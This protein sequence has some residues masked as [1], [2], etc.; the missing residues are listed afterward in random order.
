MRKDKNHFIGRYNTVIG[1]SS[2]KRVEFKFMKEVKPDYYLSMSEMVSIFFL[3]MIF[4]S[5]NNIVIMSH[6]VSKKMEGSDLAMRMGFKE[7]EILRESPI[8]SPFMTNIKRYTDLYVYTDI[9]QNQY[10]GDVRAPLLRVGPA[11]SRYGDTACVIY[12]QPQFL[13]LKRSN[14]QS[15][16]INLRSNTGELVPFRSGKSIL[17]L[18]FRRKS[19]FY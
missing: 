11:K 18:V 4:F 8:V 10:V 7:N 1:H 19:L 14:I 3:I 9:I 16:E 15:I 2:N 6:E 17:T 5:S 12:E 13:P